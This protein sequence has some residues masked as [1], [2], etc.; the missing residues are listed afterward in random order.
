VFVRHTALLPSFFVTRYGRS[1]PNADA[2]SAIVMFVRGREATG[3]LL[4]IISPMAL[5]LKA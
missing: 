2:M 5:P 3:R 4:M 1:L